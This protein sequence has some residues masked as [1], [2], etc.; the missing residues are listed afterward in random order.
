[1]ALD[2]TVGQVSGII[3]AAAVII[4]FL[5]PNALVLVLVCLLGKQHSAVTYSV[6]ARQI[7]SS[8]WPAILRSDA[9]AGHEVYVPVR[10]L[11]LL[12]PLGLMLIAL[13]AV[14]TPLGLYDAVLPESQMQSM[15]FV[16]LADSSALG[17][18]TPAQG[19]DVVINRECGG[20][21]GYSACPGSYNNIETIT[22][23]GFTTSLEFDDTYNIT[24][25]PSQR[26]LYSGGVKRFAKS[27][28]GFFD[29]R[30]RQY[31]WRVKRGKNNDKPFPVDMWRNLKTLVLDEKLEAVEG[32][33]VDMVDGR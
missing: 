21:G 10:S 33:V 16:H 29:I 11:A 27:V 8:L 12:R 31:A 15:S 24:I 5:F 7:H 19:P 20:F 30:S 4:Q 17:L 9:A 2:I 1:M 23:D 28:S 22:E 25:P 32:L 3:A 13:A 14:I 6:T 26:E 18:G